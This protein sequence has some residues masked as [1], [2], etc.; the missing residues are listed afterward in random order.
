MRIDIFYGF[1]LFEG[2]SLFHH[3]KINA[4]DNGLFLTQLNHFVESV[5]LQE[6][7]KTPLF[8]ESYG[9]GNNDGATYL[10]M[11]LAPVVDD[12]AV[13]S[14]NISN[15]KVEDAWKEKMEFFDKWLWT[16]AGQYF[17]KLVK[18]EASLMVVCDSD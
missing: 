1:P 15:L 10:G 13:T 17:Q 11:I 9:G 12:Y 4:R 14:L 7:E 5:P 3:D 16:E 18:K 2:K 6:I 8:I